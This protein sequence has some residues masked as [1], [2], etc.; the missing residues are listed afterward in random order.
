MIVTLQMME[1][2]LL[3]T[4]KHFAIQYFSFRPGVI[5]RFCYPR[6]SLWLYCFQEARQYQYVKLLP[7][8]EN[9]SK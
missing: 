1:I 7:G 9:T 5:T 3:L 8:R 6:T 4:G 2:L